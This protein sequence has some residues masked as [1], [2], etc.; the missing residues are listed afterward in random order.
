MEQSSTADQE[1]V[2]TSDLTP[3]HNEM[4][5]PLNSVQLACLFDWVGYKWMFNG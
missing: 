1:K 5:S 3:T 2:F 4:H